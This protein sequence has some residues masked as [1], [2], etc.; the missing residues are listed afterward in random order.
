MLRIGAHLTV[1]LDLKDPIELGDFARLFAAV[2]DQ[3]EAHIQLEH[4]DLEGEV[5]FYI[6]EIRDGSIIADIVPMVRDLIG[7]ADD[8]LIVA[9]FAKRIRTLVNRY[10]KGEKDPGATKK[11]LDDVVDLCRSVAHDTEGTARIESV[12]WEED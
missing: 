7:I 3:F 10:T 11:D 2:G 6:V 9:G 4:P 12:R 5:K 8:V 1:T